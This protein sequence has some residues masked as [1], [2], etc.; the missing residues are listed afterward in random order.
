MRYF[1]KTLFILLLSVSLQTQAQ[2]CTV[3]TLPV[4][5]STYD[6][7]SNTP[8]D[9]TG[10]L[11]VTCN[12]LV[13]LLVSYNVKLNGGLTGSVA[14]RIMTSGVSQMTYQLYSDSGR[15]TIMGD[16]TAGSTIINDGYLLSVVAPVI[17]NYSIYGRIAA[18][19][20]VKAGAYLDTV[21]ILLTY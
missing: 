19:Q 13:S 8:S 12:A 20:N 3:S 2:T 7:L 21:T 18:K 15:T 1:F 17:R 14:S 5:F 11:T 6:P 4:T 10:T 9:I 16:G